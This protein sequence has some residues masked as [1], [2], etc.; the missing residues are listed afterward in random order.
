M[1]GLW[2]LTPLST[3]FQLYRGVSFIGGGHRFSIIYWFFRRSYVEWHIFNM[4]VIQLL[5]TPGLVFSTIKE[6]L[7]TPTKLKKRKNTK[8]ETMVHRTKHKNVKMEIHKPYWGWIQVPMKWH[9]QCFKWDKKEKY[10][11]YCIIN[12]QQPRNVRWN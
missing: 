11:V 4:A 6:N 8:R 9:W 2:C 3:I 12:S 7:K 5:I 1:L 10:Q